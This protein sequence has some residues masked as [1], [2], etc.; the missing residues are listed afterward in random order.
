MTISG[1]KDMNG[2]SKV[3]MRNDGPPYVGG[4]DGEEAD[5]TN[6]HGQGRHA[7]GLGGVLLLPGTSF[8]SIVCMV[9]LASFADTKVYVVATA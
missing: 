8:Q 6:D 9:D 5:E 1:K 3:L 4:T 2:G 7:A